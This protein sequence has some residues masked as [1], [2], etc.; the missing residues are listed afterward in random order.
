M[1]TQ[2]NR[3]NETVLLSTQNVCL[4]QCVR[5]YLQFYAD[6]FWLSDEYWGVHPWTVGTLLILQW[7]SEHFMQSDLDRAEQ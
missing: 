2:K 5:K 1:G 6:N 7:Y 3:L 4:K